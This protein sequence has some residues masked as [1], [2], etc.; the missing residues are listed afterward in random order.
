MKI[1]TYILIFLALALIVF[2]ITLLNFDALFHGN[3]L[4]GLIGIVASFCAIAILLIFRLS[5]NVIDKTKN[6]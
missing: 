1:F 4:V 5:K 2:N 6:L 3:S